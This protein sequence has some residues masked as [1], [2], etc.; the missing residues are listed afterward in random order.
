MIEVRCPAEFWAVCVLEA[1]WDV[2]GGW[3]YV[4]GTTSNAAGVD[5]GGVFG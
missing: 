1:R 5:A 4:S 3:G 2:S